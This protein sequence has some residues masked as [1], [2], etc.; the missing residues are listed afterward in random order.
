MAIGREL[1]VTEGQSDAVLGS[2]LEQRTRRRI[3]YLALEP[4]IDFRLIGHVPAREEGGERELRIDHEVTRLRL[5]PI[6]QIEHTP[7]HRLAAV[8]LVD[9]THLGAPNP[10]HSA[11]LD[12]PQFT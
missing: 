10:K 7:H 6:E 1:S 2:L 8:R 11:H 4:G 9:W 5:G 12:L 3:G